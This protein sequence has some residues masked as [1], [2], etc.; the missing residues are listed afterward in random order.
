MT[1]SKPKETSAPAALYAIV[2]MLLIGGGVYLYTSYTAAHQPQLL[3]LTPEAKE[4]VKNL[5]LSDVEM[6]GSESYV[7]QMFVEVTGK[8]GNT[9][10][11]AL[12]TV[13][14]Y[15]VFNDPNGQLV[16][17]QRVPIVSTRTGGLKPGETK[18][19]R[20]PFDD[21]PDRWNRVRPQL[22]IAGIRFKQ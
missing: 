7:Q 14:L 22:V 8:I 12:D 2:A 10:E 17:R 9:G 4:Y 6:K 1:A 5:K 15:C 13:D 11:R 3:E 18:A 16:T 19:F 21:I 20:L